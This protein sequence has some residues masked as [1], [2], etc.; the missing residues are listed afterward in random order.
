MGTDHRWRLLHYVETVSSG[1]VN[2][3]SI[4]RTKLDYKVLQ[5]IVKVKEA[6]VCC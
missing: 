1:N 3:V 2:F 4:C 6:S 5:S